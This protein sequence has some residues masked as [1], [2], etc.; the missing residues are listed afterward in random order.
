MKFKALFFKI[1]ILSSGLVVLLAGT[2][3]AQAAEVN[4]S[5]PIITASVQRVTTLDIDPYQP[6]ETFI[7]HFQEVYSGALGTSFGYD[8]GYY[9]MEH[10]SNLTYSAN[11]GVTCQLDENLIIICHGPLSQITINFD[12]TA[13]ADGYTGQFIWWGFIGNSNYPLDYTFHLIFPAP[14]LYVR[15][16]SL[17]PATITSGQIT[18]QLNNTLS[19]PGVA[20]FQDPRVCVLYLP[21]TQRGQ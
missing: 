17:E 13:I 20:L 2:T 3:S 10:I 7:A 4:P 12:Y 19:L 1:I 18:W 16:Y 11:A 5:Q 15:S 8:I 9:G 6:F 14:L 21:L